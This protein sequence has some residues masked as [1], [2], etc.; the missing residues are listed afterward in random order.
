M[1]LG[2]LDGQPKGVMKKVLFPQGDL[3]GLNGFLVSFI[4]AGVVFFGVSLLTKPGETEK[5][6]LALFFHPSLD[7]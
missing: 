2:I 6:S 3:C 4:I 7:A 5:K 1:L